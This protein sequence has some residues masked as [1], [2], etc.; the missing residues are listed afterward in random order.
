MRSPYFAPTFPATFADF[1][2]A[3]DFILAAFDVEGNF[4]VVKAYQYSDL[5]SCELIDAWATPVCMVV[6]WFLV[7]A[8]YREYWFVLG[9]EASLKLSCG[10]DWTQYLGVFICI[11]GLGLLVVSDFKTDKNYPGTLKSA[12]HDRTPDSRGD[13]RSCQ[14][15]ARRR[16]DDPR[17]HVLWRLERSAGV[18]GPATPAVRGRRSTRVLGYHHQRSVEIGLILLGA[19]T[20]LRERTG[21]Q[22]AAIEHD[23]WHQASWNGGTSA[24]LPALLRHALDAD[25]VFFGA[26]GILIAY[27]VTMLCLYTFAPIIFRLASSVFYNISVRFEPRL[28]GARRSSCE[29]IADS[30]VGFLGSLLWSWGERETFLAVVCVLMIG[31]SCITTIPTGSTLSAT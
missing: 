16:V 5:L 27:T 30:V 20:Y 1:D 4:T 31:S 10:A 23:T 21:V 7:K 14:Q 24:L 13:V 9:R 28:V 8:R 22:A 15:A 25:A 19:A 17:S 11:V 29:R 3:T 2:R 6:A 26:V 12:S 18:P